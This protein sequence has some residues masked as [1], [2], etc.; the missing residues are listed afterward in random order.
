LDVF[1][2]LTLTLRGA[3]AVRMSSPSVL[4]GGFP[5]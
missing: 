5:G 4:L 3:V 1:H 2:A